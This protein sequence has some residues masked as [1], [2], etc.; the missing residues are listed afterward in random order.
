MSIWSHWLATLA[1]YNCSACS[2]TVQI[3]EIQVLPNSN[4][5]V[6]TLVQSYFEPE[7]SIQYH[8]ILSILQTITLETKH[9]LFQR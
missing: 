4:S 2:N 3:L 1:I 9:W 6:H 5:N 8:L 7:N